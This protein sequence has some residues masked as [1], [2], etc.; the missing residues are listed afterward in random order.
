MCLYS[1]LMKNP[2]YGYSKKNR[3]NIPVL[4]DKRVGYIAGGCGRC[5]ECLKQ[6]GSG[7]RVRLMEDVK[8]YIGAKFVTLTFNEESLNDL[9]NVVNKDRKLEGYDL[10]NEVVVLAVKRFRER[11][12]DEAE[13]LAAKDK[14]VKKTE[15]EIPERS[16]FSRQR[17]DFIDK[18]P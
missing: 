16:E 9:R 15:K 18:D 17:Q 12:D 7:W 6:K 14:D 10:D 3:G 8:D 2:K 11:R 5:M 13:S 4:K 1:T